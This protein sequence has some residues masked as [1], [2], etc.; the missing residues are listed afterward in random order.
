MV[1]IRRWEATAILGAEPCQIPRRVAATA[2]PGTAAADAPSE[3][4]L[5]ALL[6][7]GMEELEEDYRLPVALCCELGLTRRE[8]AEILEVDADTLCH[9]LE[10]GLGRLRE[11]LAR[12]GLPVS[13]AAVIGGLAHT[14][15]P[16]PPTLMAAIERLIADHSATLDSGSGSSAAAP[17]PAEGGQAPASIEEEMP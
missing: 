6:C 9:R 8:A 3:D 2:M 10:A 14:A 4:G 11:G 17:R 12:A 15:P 1:A 7:R 13:T 16:V 5:V